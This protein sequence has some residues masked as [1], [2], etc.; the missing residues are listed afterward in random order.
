MSEGRIRTTE[1]QIA[2]AMLECGKPDP[3]LRTIREAK[4]IQSSDLVRLFF[5][6]G[7]IHN[8]PRKHLQ[9][10]RDAKPSELREIKI[11][12]ID[13]GISWPTLN[14]DFSVLGL[15][16]G[17]YGNPSWMKMLA[18]EEREHKGVRHIQSST[19]ATV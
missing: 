11:L 2:R 13:T 17:H 4:Y 14:A 15:L 6:D 19:H 9:G 5:S 18:E 3:D 10:L 12:G 7:A 16:K 1:Q 8:I